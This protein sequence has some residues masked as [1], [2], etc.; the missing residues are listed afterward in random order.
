MCSGD[1]G[2]QLPIVIDAKVLA[3]PWWILLPSNENM[4]WFG[5]VENRV[6]GG[7]KVYRTTTAGKIFSNG[8]FYGSDESRDIVIDFSNRCKRYARTTSYLIL[9]RNI[10]FPAS[11]S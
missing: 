5:V 8:V 6:I 4:C 10:F 11:N 1:Y 2:R 3:I 9:R 7:R